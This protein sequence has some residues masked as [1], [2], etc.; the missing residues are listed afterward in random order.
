MNNYPEWVG[1]KV[2]PKCEG[3]GIVDNFC[4]IVCGGKGIIPDFPSERQAM[5]VEYLK[6]QDH[7]LHGGKS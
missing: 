1:H 3:S 5:E 2:C 7:I 6:F 4:C